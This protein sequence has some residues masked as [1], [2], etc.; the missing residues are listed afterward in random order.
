MSGK[1]FENGQT[2]TVRWRRRNWTE[3]THARA[4]W[5]PWTGNATDLAVNNNPQKQNQPE[6]NSDRSETLVFLGPII[7]YGYVLPS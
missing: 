1:P 3:E 4:R 5:P 2:V 7:P 6:L